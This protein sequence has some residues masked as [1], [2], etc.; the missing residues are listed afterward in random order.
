MGKVYHFNDLEEFYG[1]DEWKIT[2]DLTD[3]W[4]KVSKNEIT[5]EQFNQEYSKILVQSKDQIVKLD[6]EAWNS[7][8]PHINELTT[9][10]TKE[11]SFELYENIY[12]VCDK[13]D[14]LIKT[15]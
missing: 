14:I 13:N 15:K 8:V 12:D 3:I 11:D 7:L 6:T 9:K 4:N 5:Y 10:K 2:I 1:S